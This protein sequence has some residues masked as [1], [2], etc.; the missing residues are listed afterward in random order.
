MEDFDLFPNYEV[1]D[2]NLEKEELCIKLKSKASSGNCPY[3]QETSNRRNGYYKRYPHDLN[4]GEKRVRLELRVQRYFCLNKSCS[5]KTFGEAFVLAN[6][7]AQRCKRLEKAHTN[8]AIKIGGEAG[9]K[10]ASQLN[11][12]ISADTLLSDIK[13]KPLAPI[14]TPRVLGVDDWALKKRESYGTI[15]VDLEKHKVIDVLEGRDS[16]VLAEWLELHSGIEIITRDRSHDYAKAAREAAPQALQ[17]AD[18]WH[19]LQN[20]RQMLE[21]WFKSIHKQLFQ[22]PINPDMEAKVTRLFTLKPALYRATKAAQESSKATLERRRELYRQVNDLYAAGMGLLPISKKLGINRQTVRTYVQ[23]DAP[24][25]KVRYTRPSSILDPYIDYLEKRLA[26]GCENA[27]QLWREIVMQ[28]YPGKPWQVHRWL[29]PKRTTAAKNAPKKPKLSKKIEKKP[30]V[31]SFLPTTKQ[32]AWLFMKEA[33]DLS[34]QELCILEYLFQHELIKT[35]YNRVN[36]FKNMLSQKKADAFDDWLDE[37]QS[38]N[39]TIL[40]T[41][42]HGLRVDYDAVKA[43]IT[44]IWSNGQV[45]GQVNKLKFIKRQMYGRASFDLLRKRVLLA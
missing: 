26:E 16:E 17:V 37:G 35:M 11:I 7:N 28:G 25:D 40:Q 14:N 19:L 44:S 29:Q 32:L 41:F 22:L 38:S 21:K 27:L 15:L 5:Q 2:I 24:P 34:E 3:C 13:H 4:L 45:E 31:N 10:L 18:R 8:I 23:A 20:I 42:I 6:R 30:L 12:P 9:S 36:D 39:I 33:T 43:A 1:E